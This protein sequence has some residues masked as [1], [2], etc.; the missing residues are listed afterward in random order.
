MTKQTG[1]GKGLSSLIPQKN[2]K[3]VEV[4]KRLNKIN[5]LDEI[6]KIVAVPIN[7]IKANPY[8]PRQNFEHWS[9]EEL[10]NS[11]RE[12]GILQPLI[13]TR[14]EGGY[15]LIAGE[16]RLR[17]SQL[18]KKRVV[19][20]II[21]DA[22]KLEKLQL[23]LIE[24]I[25]RRDLNPIERAEAYNQL[26]GE[27]SLTQD[28]IA[29]RVGKPRSHVANSLRY[30][31]LPP[32]IKKSLGDERISEG[33]AKIISGLDSEEKQM[34]YY[35]R[36]V[37]QNLTVRELEAE[38]KKV[39]VKGFNRAIITDPNI[40]A[41]QEK[42]KE[43]LGTKVKISKQGKSGKIVIE[44]WSQEELDGIVKKISKN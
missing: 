23:A 38:V 44:F 1:L 7:K 34:K 26:S 12:H 5:G 28:Q 40:L 4:K 17:A 24:N 41:Q 21:R 2:N 36:V 33:H 29:K 30:L 25:Q 37:Q 43:A 3:Q 18:L 20:V 13:V 27:F 19:P 42:L 10:T 14:I 9:L 32:E 11:I 39:K 31:A 22:S 15:E 16:R 6:D 8:Q 35:K